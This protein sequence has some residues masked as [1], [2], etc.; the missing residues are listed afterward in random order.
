MVF[1]PDFIG[2]NRNCGLALGGFGEKSTFLIF[3]NSRRLDAWG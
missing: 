2:K 3:I 1:L